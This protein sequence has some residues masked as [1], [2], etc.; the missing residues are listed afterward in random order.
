MHKFPGSFINHNNELILIPRFNV[1]F[2]L[3]DVETDEDFL[4]KMCER[5]SRDCCCAMRYKSN[6]RLEKYWK[7]N[8]EKFNQVCGTVFSVYDMERIYAKLGNAIRQDLT[9]IFVRAG[10]NLEVLE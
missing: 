1:Y 2:C 9:H 8:T 4:C 5:F 10:F 6:K 7:E 3:D